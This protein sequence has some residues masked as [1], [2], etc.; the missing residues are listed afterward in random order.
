MRLFMLLSAALLAG[1]TIAAN[2]ATDNAM[3]NFIGANPNGAWSCWYGLDDG[4][5]ARM[6]LWNYNP[7]YKFASPLPGLGF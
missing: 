6:N 5:L 3:T 2:A 1:S 7:A 4:N